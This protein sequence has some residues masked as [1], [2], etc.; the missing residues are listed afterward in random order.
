VTAAREVA[1]LPFV[2]PGAIGHLAVCASAQYALAAIADG[3]LISSFAS[4]AGWYHDAASIADYYGGAAGVAERIDRGRSALAEYRRTGTVRM[5]PA[6]ESGNDRAGMSAPIPYYEDAGRG[7]VPAWTNQMAE[8][9]WLDWLGFNG[10]AAAPAVSV[11]AVFIHGDDCILPGN[12]RALP[13]R[14]SG[15]A[16]LVWTDGRQTDF[17]DQ[18]GQVM[19]AIDVAD[20]HF[21]KTL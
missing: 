16:E 11:P 14:L 3:A 12:V 13:D 6:Y 19:I 5:V 4:V 17:Y 1:C 21:R 18:P 15:P 20:R 7:A 10:L 8:L 9:S 2:A